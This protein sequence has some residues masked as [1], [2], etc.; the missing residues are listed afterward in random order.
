MS[1]PAEEL[2]SQLGGI[3]IYLLDQ[4]VRGRIQPGARVL[5]A[6]CGSGRNLVWLMR[7][8]YEVCGVD[9]DP[10][11]IRQV[12]ALAARSA[13]QLPADNFRA[14]PVEHMSFTPRSFDVVVS[15][16]VLHFAH[17]R[18]QF[19]AMLDCTWSMLRPGGLLFVRLATTIGME[20][21]VQRI[22]GRRFRLPDGSERFLADEDMLM[23]RTGEWG[24]ALAD[25]LKTTVV[26]DQRAMTTWVVRKAA[27]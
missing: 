10:A 3:D 1:S 6:G 23:S 14:E 12:R 11:A 17:D 26:Q 5:D 20:S 24:G 9:A 16:A 25:P 8:G 19:D 2:R 7:N 15:C 13:P 21:Q 22:A 4:I 27:G 18:A